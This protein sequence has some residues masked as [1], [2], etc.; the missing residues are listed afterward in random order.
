MPPIYETDEARERWAKTEWNHYELWEKVEVRLRRHKRLWILGT[1]V[2]FLVLSSIPIVV[3]QRPK[4]RALSAARQLGQEINRIKREAGVHHLA[5]RI[6]FRP[7][8]GLAYAIEQVGRCSELVGTPVR[9]GELRAEAGEDSLTLLSPAKAQEL[10]V[11]G[12]V[13][14]FCYDPLSGAEFAT[15]GVSAVG[16]GVI[17]VK[18]LA[19]GKMDRM[20]ILLLNGTSAEISF[21]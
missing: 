13:E 17:P 16:F 18:D 14:E 21:E 20:S 10:N 1:I 4:W 6:R 2:V 11:P 9:S 12:L 8:G 19:E 7:G 3:E 5:Y 15:K